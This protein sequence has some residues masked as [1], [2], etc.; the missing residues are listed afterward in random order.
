MK[1]IC[2]SFKTPK[3]AMYQGDSFKII[4]EK[5]FI[6]KYKGKVDLVFTSP[7]FPLT[8][9]KSYGNLKSEAYVKW[10]SDYAIPLTNLLSPTGSIVLEV[11]N[12]WEPDI[13]AMGT[14]TLEALLE[15]KKKANLYLCQQMIWNNTS[16]LPG[17]AVWVNIKRIRLKDAFTYIWWLSPTSQPYADNRNILREYSPAMKKLLRTQKYNSGTR[18]SEHIINA[19]SFLKK[20]KGSIASS[21]IQIND[22][23]DEIG[24]EELMN[25][26]VQSDVHAIA[27]TNNTPD[28]IT[29]CNS[30]GITPHP[31]RMPIQLADRF[32]RFLTKDKNSLVLDPF[33]GSNITGYA[34]EKL[35]R[36]WVS[37]EMDADYIAGARCRFPIK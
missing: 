31:A 11:G 37:I 10:L 26:L 16:K 3:G 36:K 19:T 22:F 20:N 28:Y 8:R 1:N 34:A 21:V 33:A 6:D 18:P 13:P 7:P 32:I 4:Q 15:F 29:K 5:W 27:H 14:W 25:Y 2:C 12:N 9:E 35:G 24:E 30:R 23:K 17:P